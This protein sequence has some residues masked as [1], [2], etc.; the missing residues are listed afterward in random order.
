MYKD[1][2]QKE[3]Q[4]QVNYDGL[5]TIAD[6]WRF[7]GIP[8]FTDFMRDQEVVPSVETTA[9]AYHEYL[10][11]LGLMTELD[12]H[13]RVRY[14]LNAKFAAHYIHTTGKYD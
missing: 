9:N 3:A 11:V 8:P 14:E 4:A 1:R 2:I 7:H 10:S 5:V 13:E 12:L 6:D